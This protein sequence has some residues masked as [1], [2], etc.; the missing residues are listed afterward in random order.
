MLNVAVL[1]GRLVADP[2]LRQTPS[3][4]S[5]TTFRIAVDRNYAKAGQER[6]ADFIDI[7]AW[8]QTAE[9]VCKYFRKG[10]MI[11]VQGSI[12]TRCPAQQSSSLCQ[13]ICRQT[14]LFAA[15]QQCQQNRPDAPARLLHSFG[16]LQ[17][18]RSSRTS[19]K[20]S[21]SVL[22]PP[23]G[24]PLAQ[25]HSALCCSFLLIKPARFPFFHC[26]PQS[27]QPFQRCFISHCLIRCGTNLLIH[28]AEY[29]CRTGLRLQH[30][31]FGLFLGKIRK[32]VQ[33]FS[34]RFG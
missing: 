34:R 2:E 12:Q 32:L 11:A 20:Q 9:F 28:P 27:R 18:E 15:R 25:L 3:G 22:G 10:S 1:M 29:F 7:V 5:V 6:Q 13:N 21:A 17:S 19:R 14:R 26:I 33:K 16:L 8:R 4:L 23:P 24:G 31:A 30:A